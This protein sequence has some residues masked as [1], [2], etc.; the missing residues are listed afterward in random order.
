MSPRPLDP[1]KRLEL[2]KVA[3]RLLAEQGPAGLTVRR[4]CSQAGCSTMALYT[5]FGGM[6][7]LVRAIVREGFTQLKSHFCKVP[8]SGDPVADLAE[9]ARAYRYSAMCQQHLFRI[10]FAGD[11]RDAAFALC[12]E[13]RQFGWSTLHT[14][15]E[16]AHRCIESRRFRPADPALVAQQVWGATHGLVILEQDGYLPGQA[17]ADRCFDAHLVCLMHGLGDELS[18]AERSVALSAQR[19]CATQQP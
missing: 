9:L 4:V 7:G 19:F 16:C 12:P 15:A 5:H 18:A 17:H 11:A 8:R 2:L 3:A 1:R 13:D 6:R 14:V 10:M